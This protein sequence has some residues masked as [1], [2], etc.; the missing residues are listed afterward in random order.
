MTITM[1]IITIAMISTI[2]ISIT[3]TFTLTITILKT[4]IITMFPT[5]PK[6]Y[7][8]LVAIQT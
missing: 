8:C 3:S 1:I 2:T 5:L 6:C 4:E 7:L